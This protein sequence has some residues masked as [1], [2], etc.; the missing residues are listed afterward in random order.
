MIAH[1]G[2]LNHGHYI[3]YAKNSITQ[4][5]YEFNDSLVTRIDPMVNNLEA[6]LSDS[7][8]VVFYKLRNYEDGL[9]QVNL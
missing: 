7:A 5:W 8:Y 2:S 9:R 1:Y 4:D 6:M 3:A